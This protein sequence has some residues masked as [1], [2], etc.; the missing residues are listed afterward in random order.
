MRT[1]NCVVTV[2]I[3]VWTQSCQDF[4][5]IPILGSPSVRRTVNRILFVSDHAAQHHHQLFSMKPNGTDIRRITYPTDSIEFYNA[6][7]SPDLTRLAVVWNYFDIQRRQEFPILTMAD[8]NGNF[9][10]DLADY[11]AG[12]SPIWSPSGER[13]AFNRT[14]SYYGGKNDI[15]V[16]NASGGNISR[17]TNFPGSSTNY[18]DCAIMDWLEGDTLVA[19]IHHDSLYQDPTGRWDIKSAKQINRLSLHGVILDTILGN[20]S[21]IYLSAKMSPDQMWVAF[22]YIDSSSGV[23]TMNG[24]GVANADGSDQVKIA[25]EANLSLGESGYRELHWSPLGNLLCFSASPQ[26]FVTAISNGTLTCIAFDSLS[27]AYATDWR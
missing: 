5:T 6:N 12:G 11:C 2:M 26:I 20:T 16:V 8:S 19:S 14:S 13:I 10:Y 21:L 9:L 22:T 24:V 25:P 4:G 7:W 3:L 1:I 27:D 15:Y 23:F 17:V 18:Y